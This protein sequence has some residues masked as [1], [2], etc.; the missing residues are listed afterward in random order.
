VQSSEHSAVSLNQK[1][2]FGAISCNSSEV[3]DMWMLKSQESF[4]TIN[5]DRQPLRLI[6]NLTSSGRI[7]PLSSRPS[8]E[9]LQDS[10]IASQHSH[11]TLQSPDSL[12]TRQW[13]LSQV[14]VRQC[15]EYAARFSKGCGLGFPDPA[16]T[17]SH[18]LWPNH[19]PKGED[20]L[21]AQSRTMTQL[22][23]FNSTSLSHCRAQLTGMH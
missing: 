23:I 6:E 18:L 12:L 20:N 19:L 17:H 13:A 7:Y 9:L 22:L 10:A 5:Y 4:R 1:A 14:H 11:S 15:G 16:D 3:P 21:R 8:E 2:V